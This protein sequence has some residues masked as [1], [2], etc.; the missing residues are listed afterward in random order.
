MEPRPERPAA[1]EA[2]EVAHRGQERLLGD[3]FSQHGVVDD[4]VR[5]PVRGGP[6][7]VE[8]RLEVRGGSALGAPHPGT[9][10][11]ARARHRRT[12]RLR[13]REGPRAYYGSA[14]VEV[15]D[16][17]GPAAC[18]AC[19]RRR[20]FLAAALVLAAV[21][22]RALGRATGGAAVALVTADLEA[23]VVALELSSGRVLTRIRTA[24]GPRSIE[25]SAYG[26]VVVAH[27]P[28]GVVT[29]LDAATLSVRAVLHG[30]GEPRYAAMHP[31]GPS[32]T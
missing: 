32:H 13:T 14:A 1:I 31:G 9:L 25:A 29:I 20:D 30:F 28:A 4:E 2:V 8:E 12:I 18:M 21:P 22:G 11:P 27:I 15:Q 24:P 17:I 10:V 7:G 19:T 26:Q 6:V 5:G 16:L 23:H 3:V